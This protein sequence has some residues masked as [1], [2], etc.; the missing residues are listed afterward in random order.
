MIEGVKVKDLKVIPDERGLLMEMWRSDDP[1]FQQFGQCYLTMVH[2]GVVKAWHYHKN[3]C[4]HFVCVGGMAKVVL[5]DSRE[6]SPT[7]GETNEFVIGWQRQ[8]M[9]II[10]EGV[11][12]GFTTVGA[13]P[14]Y[15]VNIP[16]Q[17]YNYDDPDEYRL[18]FDD[19]SIGYDW[20]VK[21]G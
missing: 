6:D 4:D 7:N 19:E 12:H 14:A 2:P 20:S 15:I 17:L 9:I 3:Q 11:Y 16:T 10:P 5:H 21:N 1:D 8:R 18:P 13:E